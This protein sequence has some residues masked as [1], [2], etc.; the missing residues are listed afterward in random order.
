MPNNIGTLVGQPIRPISEEDTFPSQHQN[1]IQGGWHT[2]ETIQDRDQIPMERRTVGMAVYVQEE[3]KI[4]QLKDGIENT[5]WEKMVAVEIDDYT[6]SDDKIWSSKRIYDEI[7]YQPINITSF[8]VS[9]YVLENGQIGREFTF[10]YSFNQTQHIQTLQIQGITTIDFQNNP[11]SFVLTGQNVTSNKTFVLIAQDRKGQSHSRSANVTFMDRVYWG[12]AQNIDVTNSQNILQLN[13]E[14]T[15]N[16]NINKTIN[17][18]SENI[19]VQIPTTYGDSFIKVNNHF[20]RRGY[21]KVSISFTNQYDYTSNYYVIR[22]MNPL[23]GTYSIQITDKVPILYYGKYSTIFDVQTN[24][25]DDIYDNFTDL[26]FSGSG[27]VSIPTTN[28]YI[29]YAYPK[30]EGLK[31][32]NVNGSF[33]RDTFDVTEFT[34]DDDLGNEIPYYIYHST[35]PMNGT[36]NISSISD[37]N[38]FFYGTNQ[39]SSGQTSSDILHLDNYLNVSSSG[40]N[41]TLDGNGEYLYFAFPASQPTPNFVVNGLTVSA[42]TVENIIVNYNSLKAEPYKVYI[43][44]NPQNGTNIPVSITF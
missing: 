6:I 42:W 1:E 16:K 23:T 30:S 32:I 29:H 37:R 27:S 31:L 18:N 28:E 5:N 24:T 26:Q 34:L 38:Y 10:T 25:S 15:T 21:E 19:Y 2:V 13:S 22:S 4:Y 11:T 3:D 41:I 39:K 40:Y 8:T 33:S 35:E 9:P 36:F 43:S 20:A 44:E 7:N 17:Q 14:L 12:Q